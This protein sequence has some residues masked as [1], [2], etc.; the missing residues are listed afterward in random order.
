[1]LGTSLLAPEIADLAAD[2]GFEVAGFV[3][4]RE[5]AKCETDFHGLPV[6]WIDDCAELS[7]T[8]VAICG[9]GTTTRSAFTEQAAAVGF[10]F[11][12]VIHPT[13]HVSRTST[14]GEGS[15]VGVHVAVGSN[16]HIG[17]HVF[18]NRGCTMGHDT[19]IGDYVSVL[20]GANIAGAC[21]VGRAAYI[22]MG[23]TVTDRI[24]IGEESV[25]AAGAVVVQDVP[26]NTQ[27][28]GVP[29]RIVKRDVRGR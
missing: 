6:H 25:V 17:R 27:V 2:A 29:A 20:P 3:E 16:T 1:V 8:H 26:P 22:A 9:L 10:R 5:R 7:S 11:A 21:V 28:V 13:A 24:S 15:I 18:L 23:A 19:R 12:T 14:I 4:N